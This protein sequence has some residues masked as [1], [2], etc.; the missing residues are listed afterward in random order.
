MLAITVSLLTAIYLLGPGFVSQVILGFV[1]PRRTIQQG[2]SE[3]IARAVLTA[4]IPLCLAVLW[5]VWHH[6]VMWQDIK[7]D[8]K[9]VFSG[10]YSEKIFEQ[11]PTAFFRAAKSA[12]LAN[13]SL[14]WRLYALLITYS[15]A[16]NIIILNYGAIR[17]SKWFGK[18]AWRKQALAIFVLPRVSEWHVLLTTFSHKKSTRITADIL[19]RSDVLY[20]GTIEKPFLAPDGSLSGLLISD[21]FRYERQRFLDD[22]KAGNNPDKD[23]YWRKIPS[24]TFLMIAAEISTIN[25][26]RYDP[27]DAELISR[28]EQIL[29]EKLT[30]Q[31]VSAQQD[32]ETSKKM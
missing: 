21:P 20:R 12:S 23:Q 30:A 3:E 1:V 19:T 28:I 18:A 14:V 25:L 6:A 32:V 5:T 7:P 15:V 16:V 29:N 31:W 13:W 11:D 10:L 9:T 27:E 2:R 4:A 17:N 8:L 22:K 24:N 26:R